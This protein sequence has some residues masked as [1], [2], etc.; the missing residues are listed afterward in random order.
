M[1]WCRT[2]K[3]RAAADELKG[4]L[5]CNFVEETTKQIDKL[6]MVLILRS[7]HPDYEHVRGSNPIK[8]RSARGTRGILRNGKDGHGRL[9]CSHCGKE[10][11]LQN[12]CYNLIGWP[13]KIANISLNDTPSNGRT[14][15]QLISDEEYQEFLRLKFNNHTQ[16]STLP[17][18][19]T[20]CI[21]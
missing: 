8:R 21:S 13:D 20:A 16:S 2:A 19:S 17:S 5:V 6:L 15:S 14:D 12:R 4:L 3:A 18:V 9:I 1:I 10:G 11:H 7:L